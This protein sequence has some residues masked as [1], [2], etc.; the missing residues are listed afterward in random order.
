LSINPLKS[1]PQATLAI[2]QLFPTLHII[3]KAL[4]A[5]KFLN[6]QAGQSSVSATNASTWHL[7]IRTYNSVLI[8][9]ITSSQLDHLYRYPE[10]MWATRASDKWVSLCDALR[11]CDAPLGRLVL[12]AERKWELVSALQKSI[13][14][15]EKQMA[16]HLLS[17]IDSM[18]EEYAYFWRR[19]CVIAC[20]DVGPGDDV[21]ASFV[22]ACATVFPPRK[23]GCDNLTLMGFLAAQMCDLFNRSRIYCSCGVIEPAAFKS[24][25]PELT[26]QDESIVAAILQ[27]RGTVDD[28]ENP[29]HE[30]KK[31]NDWRAEGLLHFVGLRL[32]FQ[33]NTVSTPIP[34][35]K[36]LFDLPSYCFD[37]HTRVG[38]KVL[39][40]LVRGAAGAEGVGDFFQQNEIRNAHRALGEALFFEEGGRIKGEMVYEPLC[41]LEQRLF[42]YQYGMDIEKWWQMR[43]LI[44]N[45]LSEGVVDR[46]REE[47]LRQHYGQGKL[48]LIATEGL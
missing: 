12:A 23:T 5:S 26:Q 2:L 7:I 45:A 36:L 46:V 41:C 11:Q 37:M 10:V 13:R 6:S 33:M 38:L 3:A 35:S 21:L 15:G 22:V 47:V 27:S 29:W 4:L 30:W 42:A 14:R 9:M 34:S 28:T 24:E 31:K 40:R 43:R 48:Q 20:E 44:Q 19:L 16:L 1:S 32:P 18:P 8:S 25:L 39:Q 17:T